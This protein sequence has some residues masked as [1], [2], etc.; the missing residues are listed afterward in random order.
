MSI[1]HNAPW[2]HTHTHKNKVDQSGMKFEFDS[3]SAGL[4]PN[5]PALLKVL[6]W[7]NT[8]VFCLCCAPVLLLSFKGHTY[9]TCISCHGR[10]HFTYVRDGRQSDDDTLISP[11]RG[12]AHWGYLHRERVCGRPSATTVCFSSGRVSLIWNEGLFI[13]LRQTSYFLSLKLTFHTSQRSFL[14][15]SAECFFNPLTLTVSPVLHWR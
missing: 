9:L 12:G 4:M 6:M 5:D 2:T 1:K 13:L 10:T 7:E 3:C 8:G 15:V 11:E 14:M